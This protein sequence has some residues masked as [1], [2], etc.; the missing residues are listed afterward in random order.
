MHAVCTNEINSLVE[1]GAA[2]HIPLD[3]DGFVSSV[4]AIPKSSGGYRP[5][6]NLKRLNTHIEYERFKMEEMEALRNLIRPRDWLVKLDLKD[7]YLTVPVNAQYQKFLRFQWETK[8][9]QCVALPFGLSS[10]P[11]TFTKLMKPVMASLRSKGVRLVI[12]LD[13]ILILNA[14][15]SQLLLELA[16]AKELIEGLGFIINYEKSVLTPSRSIE[17]LGLT[18][19]T[20]SMSL[21]LPEKRLSEFIGHCRT[22]LNVKE[23]SRKKLA[24]LLGKLTW[25]EAAVPFARA[26]YRHLQRAYIESGDSGNSSL[27]KIII[28][29]DSAHRDLKWWHDNLAR[30]NGRAIWLSEPDVEIFSD[31][32][33]SG[34]GAACNELKARGPWTPEEKIL[35]SNELELIA[36]LNALKSFTSNLSSITLR[37]YMD[38]VT[39][40]AYVYHLGGT[41]SSNLCKIA[42]EISEWCET[43]NLMIEAIYLP[44][45]LNVV[46]DAESRA[47][48]LA[49]DWRLSPI[50]FA[51]ITGQWPVDIDMF[52]AAWNSQL[53]RFFPRNP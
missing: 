34:W 28:I 17:Y 33:L 6:I 41:R 30:V 29:P 53:P 22:L 51:L 31:A 45:S 10:A 40:V 11:R 13:D 9:Y 44:G 26:H 4:F 14:T 39:A 32:S 2:I 24:Q 25:A 19:D 1:K 52:A 43:R 23:T 3:G 46:V 49:G 16:M 38:N 12:Y 47:L 27:S 8:L 48:P 42:L 37:I 50:V 21:A 5:I 20:N 18:I 35:H 15:K 7:A 36:A